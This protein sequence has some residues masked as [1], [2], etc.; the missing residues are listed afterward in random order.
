MSKLYQLIIKTPEGGN[1]IE[2]DTWEELIRVASIGLVLTKSPVNPDPRTASLEQLS[3]YAHRKYLIR[4]HKRYKTRISLQGHERA[5]I[6]CY[7]QG[8][9]IKETVFWLRTNKG[10]KTSMTAIGRYWTV[11]R[12]LGIYPKTVY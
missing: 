4:R 5:V 12:N 1:L 9:T 10:F 6:E 8:M 7:I 3:D 2:A 11:L